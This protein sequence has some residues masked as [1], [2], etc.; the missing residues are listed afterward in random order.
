MDNVAALSVLFVGIF[1]GLIIWHLLLVWWLIGWIPLPLIGIKK[2]SSFFG[3]SIF[4]ACKNLDYF[5][6]VFP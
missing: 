4:Y 3:N 2:W 5:F 1:R 6:K